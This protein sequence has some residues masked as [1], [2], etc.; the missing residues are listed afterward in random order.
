MEA[1]DKQKGAMSLLYSPKFPQVTADA[2]CMSFYFHMYGEN[3]MGSLYLILV[4]ELGEIRESQ[5]F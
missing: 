4:P 1:T 2:L 5:Q 3:G